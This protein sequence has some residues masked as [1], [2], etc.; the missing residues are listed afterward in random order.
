MQTALKQNS[1]YNWLTKKHP[2]SISN[3]AVVG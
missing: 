2:S 3:I 1:P